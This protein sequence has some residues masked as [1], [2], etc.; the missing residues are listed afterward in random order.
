VLK[1]ACLL[2]E[3]FQEGDCN[4]E[5]VERCVSAALADVEQESCTQQVAED[6]LPVDC[7]ATVGEYRQCVD[8]TFEAMAALGSLTCELQDGTPIDGDPNPASCATVEQKCP[9]WMD[10]D[11]E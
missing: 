6:P 7:T 2:V 8:D 5:R 3:A 1:F 9:G 11:E 10:D 4:D